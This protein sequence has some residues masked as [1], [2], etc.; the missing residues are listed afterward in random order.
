MED[1]KIELN[2]NGEVVDFKI[3]SEVMKELWLT[4]SKDKVEENIKNF[5]IDVEVLPNGIAT[6]ISRIDKVAVL[7]LIANSERKYQ[8]IVGS[9]LDLKQMETTDSH[10]IPDQIKGLIKQTYQVACS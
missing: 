3:D 10:Q 8:Y 7:T 6:K 4:H 2:T 1:L 9:G 5:N